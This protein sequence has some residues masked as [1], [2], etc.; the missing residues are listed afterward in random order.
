MCNNVKHYKVPQVH[1]YGTS[2]NIVKC[3]RDK[4]S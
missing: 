2:S 1:I 4:S 3:K